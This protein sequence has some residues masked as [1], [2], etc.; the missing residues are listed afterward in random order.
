MSD[1]TQV[2]I[3]CEDQQQEVF[4]RHFLVQC[5]IHPRRIR[6]QR[7]ATG[8]GAAEHYVRTHYSNE[9]CAYRRCHHLHIAL[10]VMLEA[11][12]WSVEKRL[13]ELESMLE[14]ASLAR[15]QPAERIGIFV[16]KRNIETWIYYLR[17]QGVDETTAY[18]HLT[19]PS[20][21][22]PDVARL[23]RDRQQSLPESAPPSLR[24]ACAELARILPA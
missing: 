8:H 7:P 12:V 24:A 14:A 9:V 15:R 21:C 3:L 22:K 18:P 16:P 11:D 4:A 13:H 19:N 5:G 10:V 2:V 20:D 23:A 6:V 17:G 1:Y